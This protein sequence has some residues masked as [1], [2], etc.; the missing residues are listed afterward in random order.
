[1]LAIVIDDLGPAAGAARR[2]I[3]LPRPVTLAFLPYADG[4]GS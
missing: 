1:M 3:G 2:A 4:L